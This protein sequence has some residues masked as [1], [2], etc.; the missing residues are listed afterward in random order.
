M[1]ALLTRPRAAAGR[2]AAFA[3]ALLTPHGVDRYLELLHPMLVRGEVRG[4]VTGVRRQT[5]DTVTLTVRPNRAWRGFTAGQHVRVSVDIDG[6]RH[7]RCYSPASSQHRAG[8]VELTVKVDPQGLVSR[9]LRRTAAPGMV[10]GLSQAEGPFTLPWPRP[11][12]LVL[13]SGGSGITP[14]LSMLRT[15]V[16]EG[17]T[18]EVAFVHYA[19]TPE[20]VP[21]R[22][23]L[24]GLRARHRGL[25]V[26]FG[27]PRAERSGDLPGR[28]GVEHLRVAAPFH[29]RARAYAC[30]PPSLLDAV[31]ATYA[32]ER[33]SEQLHTEEFSPPPVPADGT[34]TGTVR[35]TRSGREFAN[36]GRTL[37][38]QAEEAGLRPEHG[39][40]MGICLSCTKVKSRGH[41]RNVRT[42]ELSVDDDVEIQLC[43][44]VPG[45]DVEI[46]A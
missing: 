13:I 26:L 3:E 2:L 43:L 28:F 19:H 31:R 42:G 34:A 17:H 23:E 12:R 39:C 18:G 16:D 24:A 15:L 9:H 35:F 21:Y 7:V 22:A 8:T 29:R 6:V 10:L 37:L 1:T 5:R 4:V 27:H 40:R 14:V 38:E 33:L 11:E 20:D 36:S 41:V 46:D 44:S 32:A 25:R 45:G 30:G